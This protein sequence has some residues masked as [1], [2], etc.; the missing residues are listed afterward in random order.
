MEKGD[1]M[2][3]VV[4]VKKDTSLWREL[5][6]FAE[7]CSW[8]AGGHLAKMLRENQFQDWEAV[9]A[10]LSDG[11]IVGYCTLLKTDYYPENRYSPWISS[12][13]VDEKSRGSRISHALI[14]AASG[15][16]RIKGFSKVYIPSDMTGFYEKC[17]FTKIDEL[18]NYGGNTDSIFAKDIH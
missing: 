18:E 15:Y 7:H 3:E 6:G 9:F 13:F 17:G 16:A 1:F 2:V 8:I 14:E 5:A 12:I 10:A 11:K 4:Q